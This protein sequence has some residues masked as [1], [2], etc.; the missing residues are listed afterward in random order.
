MYA[1]FSG[2]T[3]F[4]NVLN[5]SLLMS[6]SVF[7]IFGPIATHAKVFSRWFNKVLMFLLICKTMSSCAVSLQLISYTTRSVYDDVHTHV[8]F[9]YARRTAAHKLRI[10]SGLCYLFFLCT[11]PLFV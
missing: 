10:Y 9:H 6:G 2:N 7:N 8:T 3:V 4:Y 11:F 5:Y 1:Y